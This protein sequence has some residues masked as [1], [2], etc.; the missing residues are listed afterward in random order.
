M[1]I[2]E[3]QEVLKARRLHCAGHVV[4][5]PQSCTPLLRRFKMK[6]LCIFLAGVIGSLQIAMAQDYPT[7]PI[8]LIVPLAAGGG[9]D[10]VSRIIT[11]RMRA[12]LGQPIVVENIPAAAGTVALARLARATP[13][14]Y[15]LGTGD[16]TSHVISSIINQVQYD[17]MK[18]FAP[19][20]LLSTSPVL[21]VGRSSLPLANLRELIDWLRANP[22]KASL[23]TFGQ[24][25]G[26]HIIGGAFQA[27]TATQLQV[28]PYRGVAPALQDLLAGHVDLLFVEIAGALPYVREGK[29]HAYAVLAPSRS[30]VAPEV[31]TIEEAGGP[32]LHITTWRGLWAPHGTPKAI[33][34]KVNAAVVEA[35]GDA[36]IQ[37]RVAAT[38][39]DVA[40]PAQMNPQALAAHHRVEM[41]LWLG[42]IQP[43]ETTKH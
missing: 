24:G 39:Q 11:E 40:L 43:A 41:D 8:T 4:N 10:I 15:T 1:A 14:G 18:D 17:V 29:L 31:P 32:S 20:S 35:L 19:I 5:F 38:G 23:A 21:F 37:K 12:S 42:L 16:Q 34:D 27:N 6:A 3:F 30:P 22:G 13:D 2:T 25:S 33:I 9:A 26:P 28:V 7:R 36:Q